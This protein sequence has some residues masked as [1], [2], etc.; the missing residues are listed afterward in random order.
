MREVLHFV[1][2]LHLRHLRRYSVS[3]AERSDHRSAALL[4]FLRDCEN[5]LVTAIARYDHSDDDVLQT[6]VQS[7]PA[8]ALRDADGS[9]WRG[10][11]DGLVRDY[12]DRDAALI[13]VFEQ[14]QAGLMPPRA[15]AIFADLAEMERRNQQRLRQALIDF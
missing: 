14:L 12:R 5:Q 3:L 8:A 1:L 13:R 10:E 4:A 7:V 6:F 2:S 11:L 15:K 9:Q